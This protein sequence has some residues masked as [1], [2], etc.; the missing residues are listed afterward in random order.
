M[1]PRLK[2]TIMRD[3]YKVAPY[4]VA[5]VFVIPFMAGFA[6]G[7]FP[8]HSNTFEV[9]KV[10]AIL[11]TGFF[12]CRQAMRHQAAA[13]IPPPK[14]GSKNEDGAGRHPSDPSPSA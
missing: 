5:I 14:L 7:R 4:Y 12:G 2:H 9:V 11:A 3:Y 8:D 6:K 10:L 1:H 13:L